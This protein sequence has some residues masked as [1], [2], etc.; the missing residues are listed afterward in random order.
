MCI[1]NATL[2]AL[3]TSANNEGVLGDE[4]PAAITQVVKTKSNKEHRAD[5][6]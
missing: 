1:G 2:P 3:K 4:K 5:L 6:D